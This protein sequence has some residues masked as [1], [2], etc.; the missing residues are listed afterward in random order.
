MK[1]LFAWITSPR[2]LALDAGLLWMRL[3]LG[4]FMLVFHGWGKLANFSERSAKFGDPLGVGSEVS[5]AL[6]VSAEVFC[7][8]LVMAGAAT[9]FAVVPLLITMGVAAGI[10][11]ADDPWQKQEF[12]LLY[13][14]PFFALFLTGPGKFSVD[15]WLHNRSS[16]NPPEP[17]VKV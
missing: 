12:A 7:S 4:G 14:I 13:L 11:H 5:L 9:R 15:A 16:K 1:S 8:L 2:A 3:M 17:L 10:V 6:A